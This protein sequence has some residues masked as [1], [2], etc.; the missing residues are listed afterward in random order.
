MAHVA[1]AIKLASLLVSHI[2]RVEHPGAAGGRFECRPGWAKAPSFVYSDSVIP[3]H[4]TS[5]IRTA[6]SHSVARRIPAIFGPQK[7]SFN[8]RIRKKR[9]VV[10]ICA[11][12]HIVKPKNADERNLIVVSLPRLHGSTLANRRRSAEG[13]SPLCGRFVKNR[14]I[15]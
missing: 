6:T 15:R 11:V 13:L 7:S 1:A 5:I 3:G 10:Y 12:R 14:R 2:R 8:F 4:A 9:N